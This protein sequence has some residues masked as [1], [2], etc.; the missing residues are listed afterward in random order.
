MR[1]AAPRFDRLALSLSG[2]GYRAA[3]FHLGVLL[4]LHRV[5][6]LSN[7]RAL[8]TASGGSITGAFYAQ[9]A[10][11]RLPFDEIY[12]RC[13]GF[14]RDVDVIDAALRGAPATRRGT[15]AKLITSAADVYAR[16]LLHGTLGELRGSRSHLEEISI[17]A[18]ELT[19][20]IA[21]RFVVTTNRRV[22]SGNR[23]EPVPPEVAAGIRLADAV[24]ASSSFPGAFEP[25]IF[26]TDFRWPA[27]TPDLTPLPL[28]DGGIYDNQGID[29]LLLV[30]SRKRREIDMVLIS[31]AD[32]G[33]LPLYQEPG[34]PRSGAL[35]IFMLAALLGLFCVTAA[36]AAAMA[37]RAGLFLPAVIC[38]LTAIGGLLF[39]IRALTTVWE[40]IAGRARPLLWR[41]LLRLTFPELVH[42]VR[43][44]A[45]SLVAL[46]GRIFMKRV[47]LLTYQRVYEHPSTRGRTIGNMIYDLVENSPNQTIR[48]I[49]ARASSLPTLLWFDTEDDLR[50]TVAVGEATICFNVLRFLERARDLDDDARALHERCAD[51]WQRL[52]CDPYSDLPVAADVRRYT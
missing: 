17:N 49:A 32:R 8:S 21:F 15:A 16:S 40:P 18:T 28:M 33:A 25:I 38:A 14:L 6:L 50:D 13:Y 7:V 29:S 5:G 36:V 47:R 51:L 22:R 30:R 10:A 2:G 31:D 27:A 11:E 12:R 44:R 19:R 41:R 42:A 34:R 43:V 1:A 24:A 45:T 52:T 4:F 46:T 20:G 35:P 9:S 23:F 26:P 39:V 3:A 37:G 48:R